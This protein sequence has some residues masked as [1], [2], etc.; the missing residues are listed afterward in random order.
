MADWAIV[1]GASGG[2]G[3][4]YARYLA[5]CG[6]NLALVA[7]NTAA[8]DELAEELKFKWGVETK[9]FTCDL[10]D[11]KQRA[12]LLKSLAELPVDTLVNNAGYG[13]LGRFAELD[14]KAQA[15]MIELNCVALT[16]L[17]H[18]FLPKMLAAKQ[19]SIINVA[20][21]A[22]FQP[23]PGMSVYAATK[24]YVLNFT[25]GLAA[26]IEGTGVRCIAICP[27]P[28]DT[29]FFEVAGDDSVMP[30]RRSPEQVVQTTFDGLAANRS[31]IV[32]GL[33]NRTL[34]K[35]SSL[36]PQSL[37]LKVTKKLFEKVIK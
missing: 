8:M 32:D 34:A 3:K 9:V 24:S 4:A 28:T 6:L 31:Y 1:T 20:S 27:G 14:I 11:A 13:L 17:T 36:A 15:N 5:A 16:E 22:S 35:T 30:S 29:A 25:T 23:L 18:A 10:A 26:E 12:K 21:T 37:N 2:L 7:R 19:G 33:A